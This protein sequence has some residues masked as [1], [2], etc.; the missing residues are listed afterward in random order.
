MEKKRKTSSNFSPR[1]VDP[2]VVEGVRRRDGCCLYGLI[3]QDG[4]KGMLAVHHIEKRSQGGDDVPENLIVLC[5][6]HHDRAERNLITAKQIKEVMTRFHGY[7]YK[8]L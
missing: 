7:I 6:R 2:A 8:E 5:M 4:C 1:V 3:A